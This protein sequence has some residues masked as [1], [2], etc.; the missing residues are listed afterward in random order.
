MPEAS[1]SSSLSKGFVR[2][3]EKAIKNLRESIEELKRENAEILK[4]WENKGMMSANKSPEGLS[5]RI[6]PR[7]QEKE[8]LK[9]MSKYLLQSR[10]RK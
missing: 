7:S 2:K 6:Q 9:N 8:K 3:Y 5:Q 4:D 10:Q 1:C